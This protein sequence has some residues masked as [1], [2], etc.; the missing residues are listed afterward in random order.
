M[1]NKQIIEDLRNRSCDENIVRLVELITNT[2][3][4]VLET[5]QKAGNRSLGEEILTDLETAV[6]NIMTLT[7]G[8]G[9]PTNEEMNWLVNEI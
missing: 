8:E 6:V 4:N 2:R 5:S 1:T 3:K 7:L 9:R